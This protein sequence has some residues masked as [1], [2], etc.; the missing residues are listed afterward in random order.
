M[1]PK[2]IVQLGLYSQSFFR[3]VE[4]VDSEDLSLRLGKHDLIQAYLHTPQ[5]LKKIT[6][7]AT[8]EKMSK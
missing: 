4:V 3:D 2:Y 1:R 8:V 6:I 5:G 7:T